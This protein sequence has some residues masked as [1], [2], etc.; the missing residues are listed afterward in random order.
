MKQSLKFIALSLVTLAAACG[1]KGDVATSPPDTT[2]TNPPPAPPPPPPPPTGGPSVT[3]FAAGNIAKCSNNNAAAT[4][5][6]IDSTAA[7]VITIGNA[8]NPNGGTAD[9]TSCFDPTW[10]KF[11]SIIHPAI[12]NHDY[13][14]DSLATPY[15]AYFGAAAGTAPDGWYSF[16]V[17]AWHVVVLNT[18]R[19]GNSNVYNA[20]SQQQAWL[21]A[22]L[23]AHASAKCTMAVWH[24]PRFLSSN[25]PGYT[26]NTTLTSLW[27]LLD[28]AGVDVILNAGEY[29]YERMVPLTAAGARDDAKGMVQFNVGLGGENVG[30]TFSQMNSN[31]AHFSTAFGVLK[32]TLRDGSADYSYLTIPS[33]NDPGDTGSITCH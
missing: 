9:Y 6:L 30:S 2:T 22:D 4:A 25:T 11:K 24:R 23:K 12:G 16:D 17:G 13:L 21:A 5:R 28:G 31:S 32:L 1:S 20:A 26:E 29:A 27:S 15:F 8:A 3:V 19:G 7:A 14:P 10:G 33:A 18:E